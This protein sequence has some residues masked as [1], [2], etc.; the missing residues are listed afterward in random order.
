MRD[1]IIVP[2]K[3][4]SVGVPHKNLRVV[5]GLSLVEHAVRIAQ[6]VSPNIVVSTD[7]DTIKELFSDTCVEVWHRDAKL[8][9]HDTKTEHV[10]LD[11]LKALI[12]QGRLPSTV[13][14]VQCTSPF[15]RPE[16][17]RSCI[18]AVDNFGHAFTVAPTS[19]VFWTE[20][21]HCLSPGAHD[22]NGERLPRQQRPQVLVETGGCYSMYVRE[23]LANPTRFCGRGKML[24]VCPKTHHEIDTKFDLAVAQAIVGIV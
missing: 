3:G 17:V 10:V 13:S 4:H 14:V 15:T 23:F 16:D 9:Q 11:I 2:A 21:G 6:Q 24:E 18:D 22:E 1:L 5:G 19:D 12:I 7:S 20:S 8:C